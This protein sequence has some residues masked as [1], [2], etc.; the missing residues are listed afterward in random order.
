MV[1]GQYPEPVKVRKA[2]QKIEVQSL[3]NP[4]V[5]AVRSMSRA[6][7]LL[8]YKNVHLTFHDLK[9]IPD[10]MK[11]KIKGEVLLTQSRVIFLAKDQS[12]PLTSFSMPFH[13]IRELSVE[14]GIFSA[15][16]IKG[17]I[18]AQSEGGWEGT[19]TFK[20]TFYSGGAIE[21]GKA[22]ARVAKYE[23]RGQSPHHPVVYAYETIHVIP[24]RSRSIS[25]LSGPI[26]DERTNYA[27]VLGPPAPPGRYN[28][29]AAF[30]YGFP[31]PVYYGQYGYPPPYLPPAG[32]PGIPPVNTGFALPANTGYTL[33]P[34]MNSATR[35]ADIPPVNTGFTSPANTGYT[36]SLP[37][38]SA[39]STA[40]I[41][42]FSYV[43]SSPN[44][45][46][47]G[48]SSMP[49]SSD[50]NPPI[51]SMQNVPPWRTTIE[52]PQHIS[53]TAEPPGDFNPSISSLRNYY[54]PLWHSTI[55]DPPQVSPAAE[56][57]VP[58][59]FGLLYPGEKTMTFQLIHTPQDFINVGEADPHILASLRMKIQ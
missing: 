45:L 4:E 10:M 49:T 57:P 53:L 7:I 39:T 17:K 18:S 37:T 43:S 55:E 23:S 16:Y 11:G 35:R 20:L 22:A 5:E 56:P 38:P 8:N 33:S 3:V 25:R 40:A 6:H 58:P 41:Q 24:L 14:Q 30:Q 54:A 36:S 13:L 2:K 27:Y 29:P 52:E 48:T 50:F 46:V 59:N 51:S 47:T 9:P 42:T 21:F 15:N 26:I 1:L 44:D 19:A 34:P 32:T 31:P 28:V 12:K